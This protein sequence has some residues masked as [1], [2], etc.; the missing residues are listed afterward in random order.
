MP[1]EVIMPKVDMDMASGK[2]SVWHVAAGEKVG[3]GDPLFD[4]ETD[5]AA[6]E[7]EAS[8]SGYLHHP[9]AE[10][11]DVPIGQ[12]V[13][14]IYAEGEK[15]GAPPEAAIPH[16]SDPAPEAIPD[17]DSNPVATAPAD[18]ASSAPPAR[19][20]ARA[21]PLARSLARKAGLDIEDVAGS[22]PRGRVQAED[23]RG[24]LDQP[25]PLPMAAPPGF[26]SETGPLAVSRSKAGSGTP[27]LLIH[28][29]ASDAKSWAPLEGYL[30]DHPIFRIELPSHG[31]SPRLRISCFADLVSAVRRAFDALDLGSAH[32]IGHSL[33]GAAALA[34]AD[35]RPKT[36]CS[37]T[38]LAPAGLGPDING[39]ALTGIG[40]ATRAES[41]GPWLKQ[42]VADER[43]I[44]DGYV[45]AAMAARADAG[46][47]LA[48]NAL[49]D[50]VFPDGVQAFDMKSA[51]D[52]VAT[53]TRIVWGRQDRIIPWQHALRAPGR[54]SLH[55]FDNVGHVPQFEIPDEVGKLLRTHL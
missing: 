36:V 10:G 15:V 52:R 19:Q 3:Q 11:T 21:T 1:V 30:N 29:F 54:V 9:V 17:R 33:G 4:I 22:G 41:L 16:A 44:G 28:G 23:V 39:Q 13:A 14:W 45:R 53:P 50:A 27:I 42:T 32:L 38:L 18:D 35:T 8:A 31:K 51:L 55:L 2:I 46:M 20:K 37:L 25:L 34:L 5:K 48:Q 12:P 49:A 6:M 26:V 43:L 40:N 24:F 47:R 7:V